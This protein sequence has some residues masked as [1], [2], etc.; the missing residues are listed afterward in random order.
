MGEDWVY[1]YES[2]FLAVSTG[3]IEVFVCVNADDVCHRTKLE[4]GEF[5]NVTAQLD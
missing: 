1:G 4:K 3:L 2:D 5:S